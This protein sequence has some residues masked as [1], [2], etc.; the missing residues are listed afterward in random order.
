MSATPGCQDHAGHGSLTPMTRPTH[1]L[2]GTLLV[3]AM[4]GCAQAT[5]RADDPTQ[6]EQNTTQAPPSPDSSTTPAA[7]AATPRPGATGQLTATVEGN[8]YTLRVYPLQR[9]GQTLT[10]TAELDV[11][12]VTKERPTNRSIL[13]DQ[14]D[15]ISRSKGLV[16]GIGLIDPDGATMFM[17]A[18]VR[19]NA[20]S[21]VC[22]P[23]F[24]VRLSA[25]DLV[26]ISCTYA[27]IPTTLT[28]LTVTAP[29]F[30]SLPNVPIR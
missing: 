5:P 28:S 1:A 6:T 30:G 16:N 7:G 11:E 3:L 20:D 9:Q 23:Q 18:T 8:S 25:G 17:P 19:P 15:V 10:L 22:S 2:V 21:A 29:T 27:Q 13:A 12:T 24:P 4:A 14:S 26:T